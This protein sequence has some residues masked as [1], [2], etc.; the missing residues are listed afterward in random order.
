MTLLDLGEAAKAIETTGRIVAWGRRLAHEGEYAAADNA[1]GDALEVLETASKSV[2]GD[3]S[4]DAAMARA[5]A[6][7]DEQNDEEAGEGEAGGEEG[8][9]R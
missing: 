1:M 9:R 8:G 6:E 4:A 5:Q 7:W 3:F 2:G